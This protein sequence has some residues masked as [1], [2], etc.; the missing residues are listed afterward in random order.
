VT[1]TWSESV[2]Y[3]PFT[4]N[5]TQPQPWNFFGLNYSVNGATFDPGQYVPVY[6]QM[7]K[8]GAAPVQSW[9]ACFENH[10]L[11]GLPVAAQ[12]AQVGVEIDIVGNGVIQPG[13]TRVGLV[14]VLQRAAPSPL[15][16]E[17]GDAVSVCGPVDPTVGY[18][19]TGL[20]MA[21]VFSTACLDL[22]GAQMMRN[23]PALRLADGQRIA[24]SADGQMV[25]WFDAAAKRVKISDGAI[26]LLSIDQNGALRARGAVLA[27]TPP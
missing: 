22:R 25:L 23:A 6:G 5:A 11:S 13:G 8:Y 17:G 4:P 3:Q 16:I 1:L 19:D 9:A 18:W 21:G 24:L 10:D 26:D 20:A 2:I 14:I 12:A 7:L 27:N 15:A